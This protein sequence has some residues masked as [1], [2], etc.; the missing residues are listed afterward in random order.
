MTLSRG[1]LAVVLA[2]C[3]S[4]TAAGKPPDP[5]EPPVFGT[6]ISL[7]SVPAFVVDKDGHAMRGLAPE[8]FELVEDGKPARV[9][10]FQYIDTTEA[11][12]QE[13]VR[14][15]PAARRHFLLLFDMSF[16]EP[17]GLH[18]A[19]L[20]AGDLLRRRLAPTDLAAVA[21]FDVNRGIRLVANFTEDRP[22][23]LHAVDTLGVSDLARINDPLS[24]AADIVSPDIQ[25]N[26]AGR[27]G[28]TSGAVTDQVSAAILR[29]MRAA[30]QD[31]Y[32]RQVMMLVGSLDELAKGLRGV[33]GRK[34]VLYF[35]A[36]F[37]SEALVGF[38]AADARSANLAIAEGRMQDVDH[39]SR[40]GDA[41]LRG[42]LNAMTKQL[43]NAD[44]VVHSIDVTGL[45]SDRGLTRSGVQD[46]LAR[47][48]SGRESLNYLANETGGRFFKDAN[49]L[50]VALAEILDMTSRYYILGYQ[51]QTGRGPGTFHKLKVK[52]RR[53][54]AR[55]SHRAGYFER[56][57]RAAQAPLQRKFE[58]AQLVMTGAGTSDLGFSALCLPFPGP[59]PQQTLGVVLQVPRGEVSWQAGQP[60]SLEVY[61]YAVAADGVVHDHWAQ[62][63][64]FDPGRADREGR[65]ARGVSF[66]GTLRVPPGAYTLKL[67]VQDP[68]TGSAG[69]QFLDVTVPPYEANAG[70]LLPPVVMD[71]AGSWLA[72]EISAGRKGATES[73]FAVAGHAFLPRTSFQVH[74]GTPEKLVLIA[75][76]P[77]A[78][79]D[80]AAG[81][82]IR[83]SLRNAAGAAVTGGPLRL[84]K[85][86]REGNGR[87]TYVLDYTPEGL[88][89]GDYTLRIGIGESGSRLESYSLLRVLPGS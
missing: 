69:V 13:A 86:H 58:A 83:S 74:S 12:E 59:G 15:P 75:Y 40:Y 3:F 6:E 61:G 35:S 78:P 30:D 22:L 87:R 51:P 67:M 81:I 72:L 33:E 16:T 52:V 8:D 57:P 10:S 71:D 63:A 45:G 20:A 42:V 47:D 85:M 82:E 53:K 7:V 37:N 50:G 31:M 34:Q 2:V 65:A 26:A 21:T 36:G 46:D 41:T 62:L 14:L 38:S 23:L 29:M 73:P 89:P 49:D 80:P 43:S 19:R 54:G 76:E 28:E 55:V 39:A 25:A 9:V 5:S 11:E 88:A 32:R 60:L 24:L 44:C 64:R 68:E 56:L 48:I 70:F 18:R 1:P 4:A 27:F 79:G 77:E 84:D 66:Y 17:G